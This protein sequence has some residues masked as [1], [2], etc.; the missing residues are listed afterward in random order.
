THT[1][2]SS[3]EVML[4]ID[5]NKLNANAYLYK[6]TSEGYEYWD[7]AADKLWVDGSYGRPSNPITL[8]GKRKFLEPQEGDYYPMSYDVTYLI[9]IEYMD[10]LESAIIYEYDSSDALIGTVTV[11][12]AADISSITIDALTSYVNIEQ[13]YKTGTDEY[14]E[15]T[16]INRDDTFDFRFSDAYGV[17]GAHYWHFI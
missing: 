15:R 3:V 10:S 12:T 9:N 8:T 14:S 1:G 11:S 5:L 4:Y 2:F 7:T 6:I 16:A 17:I 13:R